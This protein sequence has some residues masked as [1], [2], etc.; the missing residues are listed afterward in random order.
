MPTRWAFE[1]VLLLESPHHPPPATV[2]GSAS[3][4]ER[5]LA[6][7]FFPADI[8]TDGPAADAMALA[9]MLIG[10]AAASVLHRPSRDN[11]RRIFSWKQSA[12][13]DILRHDCR[14]CRRAECE[15]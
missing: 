11:L 6:E 9:S 4:P 2:D 7:D 13:S 3:A 1:G 12:T 15:H 10:L 14:R 5:D 8:R